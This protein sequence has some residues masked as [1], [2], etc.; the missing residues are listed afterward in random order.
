MWKVS[1]LVTM[2]SVSESLKELF[3]MSTALLDLS[4]NMADAVDRAARHV[5]SIKEGGRSG[6]SGTVW[7]DGVIVAA[8]RTIRGQQ[9]HPR[10]VQLVVELEF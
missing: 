8:E 7:K 4:N 3:R 5:V 2:T 6:V 9:R 10:N 1:L